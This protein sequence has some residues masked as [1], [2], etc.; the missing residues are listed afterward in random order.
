M[1]VGPPPQDENTYILDAESTTEMARLMQQD[2]LITQGMGGL[3][4]ERDDVARMHHILDIACGP[5]GWVLDVAYTYPKIEVV[6]IDISHTMIEYAAARARVQSLDNAQFQV[7]N[8]L[9]QLEFPD[10]FFDLVNA[11]F[12]VAFMP[13]DA[14]PRLI[15]ECR[16]ITRPGGVI[17]LT[18]FD[19]PGTTNSPAFEHWKA[20]T[21][22]AIQKAGLAIS[23]DG[24]HFGITPLLSR[25][26][27]EAGCEN[28]D[29]KAYVVDFS[30]GTPGYEI[31]YQNCVV[32]FKQVQPLLVKMGAATQ[33]EADESY[34][35]MIVEMLSNEF[36]A[37][38]YYLTAWGNKPE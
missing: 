19:E 38:W 29:L 34:Q 10:N 6:G 17:R 33:E 22:H 5:G 8:A 18:D 36:C 37:L 1:P 14:W 28:I 4:P 27:R 12:I 11:R 9:K 3:F 7:V 20:L 26:L 23:P 31:M 32:A 13:K 25:F 16:R 30:T 21:F 24:R 35:Q 15:Q 2:R